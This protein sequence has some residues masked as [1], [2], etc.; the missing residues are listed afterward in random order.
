MQKEET[1]KDVLTKEVGS[2]SEGTQ[3]SERKN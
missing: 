2:M 3:G 1:E